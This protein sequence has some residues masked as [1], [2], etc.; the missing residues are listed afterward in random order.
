MYVCL[1]P[2]VFCCCSE[3][4]RENFG[5][6]IIIG[7]CCDVKEE[8]EDAEEEGDISDSLLFVVV[9]VV[10]SIFLAVSMTSGK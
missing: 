8:E 6:S 5:V 2:T 4:C 3:S 7:R 1:E 10:V 9:V